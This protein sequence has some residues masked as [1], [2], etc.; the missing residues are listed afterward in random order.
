MNISLA[1]K[2][3]FITGAASGLGRAAAIEFARAG[4]SLCL[5]DINAAGLE[6]TRAA[7]EELGARCLLQVADISRKA[8]C[9]AAIAA[10]VAHFGRLDVLANVAGIVGF[11]HA[12]EVSEAAWEKCLAVNLSGPFY[13][14]QAAIPHLLETHGNIVN[15]ASIGGVKG[16]AYTV[17]YSTAKAGLLNMTR[18]M[19]MEY[20]H[21][22]IRINAVLPG[23]MNTEMAQ[24]VT[25]PEGLDMSLVQRILNMR[26]PSDP[27]DVARFI[28]YVASDHTA[29]LHGACLTVDTG[30]SAG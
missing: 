24:G 23:A 16:Q 25:M 9:D 20:M 21:K 8:N 1:G 5:A 30:A 10:A 2:I 11:F 27:A 22:P 4:A 26:P 14:S 18:S 3:V 6:K 28:V 17:P 7:V 13:L 15:V 29:S 12:T 19:A